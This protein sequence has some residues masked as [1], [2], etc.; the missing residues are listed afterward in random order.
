MD[1]SVLVFLIAWGLNV[2]DATVDAHLKGFDVSDDLTVKIIPGKSQLANTTGVS[3]VLRFK[4]KPRVS[5][6]N[7]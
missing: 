3:L 6:L 2:V 5:S 4:D 7:Y 1:Y